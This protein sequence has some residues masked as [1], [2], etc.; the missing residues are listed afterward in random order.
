MV[1]GL[2]AIIVMLPIA[3][4]R[5]APVSSPAGG[6]EATTSVS[7]GTSSA[8]STSSAAA[9]RILAIGDSYT[10][11]SPQE[12][13]IEAGWPTLL[14]QRMPELEID[15]AATE[16]AGYV[17]TAGEQTLSELV[18][19]A[20]LTGVDVVILFGSRFDA[21]GI[22]DQVGT[23]ARDVFAA[24]RQEAPEATLLVI[25]PAWPDA[26]PPAGVRN[27][28]DV[29]EAAAQAASVPFVDPLRQ[30]WL[31]RAPDAIGEDGIHLTDAGHTLLADRIQP[32]VQQALEAP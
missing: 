2:V 32:I 3:L 21:P 9:V 14:E 30:G 7:P 15:V 4:N 8:P 25:G 26:V 11:G 16:D 29:I 20:D 23:T 19:D 12:E 6:A 5:T 10:G 28:R 18:A 1:A 22:A 24:I 27:N 17:T 31:S 13:Q